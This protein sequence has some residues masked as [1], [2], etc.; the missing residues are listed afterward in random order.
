[1]AT[2]LTISSLKHPYN[3]GYLPVRG[4]FRVSVMLIGCAA[5]INIRRIHHDLTKYRADE[6]RT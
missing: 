1:M 5:L 3:Y 2:E 4:R 6:D